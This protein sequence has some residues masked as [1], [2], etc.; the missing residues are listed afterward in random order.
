MKLNMT[1][2]V[3][4]VNSM[5]CLRSRYGDAIV[6][7]NNEDRLIVFGGK[8]F[9]DPTD[10]SNRTVDTVEVY[11]TETEKW[12]TTGMKLKN[13]NAEFGFLTVNLAQIQN[14]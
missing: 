4:S 7:I 5:Y 10:Y 6:T 3:D 9:F 11:N 13:K 8:E 2:S 1:Q 14:L 12:E